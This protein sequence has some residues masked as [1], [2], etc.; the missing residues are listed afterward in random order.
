LEM[1]ATRIQGN[2]ELDWAHGLHPQ[3]NIASS[4]LALGDVLSWYRALQPDVTE[5][6]GVDCAVGLD[7]KLGG[8][9]RRHFQCRRNP[10]RE[11]SARAAAHRRRERKRIARWYRSCADGDFLCT[12]ACGKCT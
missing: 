2:G 9:P 6:L 1:P 7:L 3:L 8:W 11:I 5:D 10:D 4:T 12:H